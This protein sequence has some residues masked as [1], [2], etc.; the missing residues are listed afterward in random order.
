MTLSGDNSHAVLT[1]HLVRA[2][3][4]ARACRALEAMNHRAGNSRLA[5]GH[6]RRA[7]ALEAEATDL[8]R[9][10]RSAAPFGVKGPL[11]TDF[12]SESKSFRFWSQK[13][14]PHPPGRSLCQ[15][16]SSAIT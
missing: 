2:R 7:E 11:N 1:D 6:A 4:D 12:V 10:L 14:S 15:I 13:E 8:E 5:E 9:R 16:L 3:G